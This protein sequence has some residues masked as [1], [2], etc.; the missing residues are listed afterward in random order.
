MLAATEKGCEMCQRRVG[1]ADWSP[2]PEAA[3]SLPRLPPSACRPP[4]ITSHLL[5][6]EV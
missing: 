6:W 4:Q 1:P 2:I 3:L 5:P